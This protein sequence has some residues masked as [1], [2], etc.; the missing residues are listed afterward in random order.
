VT[1]VR[2][3]HDLPL[4][5]RDATAPLSEPQNLYASDSLRHPNRNKTTMLSKLVVLAAVGLARALPIT[6]DKEEKA[7]AP[8]CASPLEAGTCAF[9]GREDDC[10][11]GFY[12][13]GGPLGGCEC[14]KEPVADNLGDTNAVASEAL[15]PGPYD[16]KECHPTQPVDPANFGP[17]LDHN[18]PDW[19]TA[20]LLLSNAVKPP[21]A[22]G[23]CSSAAS[24]A[25]VYR[26]QKG[27][28]MLRSYDSFSA[29][30]T[31]LHHWWVLD[32]HESQGHLIGRERDYRVETAICPS[33]NYSSPI[34]RLVVC[35]V[36]AG[37]LIAVGT[38]QS[39]DCK[40]GEV[41]K[42]RVVMPKTTANQYYID[43]APGNGVGTG[44]PTN[45]GPDENGKRVFSG[46]RDYASAFQW[47]PILFT[48][49]VPLPGGL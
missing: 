6:L 28:T 10:C 8:A 1:T 7:V 5:F 35:T 4:T 14:V 18:D 3:S 17:P 39:L 26:L 25:K 21:L 19:D 16:L 2:A 37:T 30:F 20:A 15:P 36:E 33:G 34:D 48:G 42:G 49:N 11:P 41:G 45:P 44:T 46:C 31:R 22:G 27:I 12:P 43:Y 47:Q 13:Q 24:P 32:T 29:A 9:D 38:G 23:I 40:N